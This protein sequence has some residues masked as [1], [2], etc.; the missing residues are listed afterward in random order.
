MWRFFGSNQA[1]SPRSRKKASRRQFGFEHLEGRNLLAVTFHGGQLL[2]HVETQAVYL[3]SD[4]SNSTLQSQSAAL[5]QYLGYLVQ[6]P[7]M[8]MLTQ[9]GYGV[10]Q[11]TSTAGKE[12]NLNISKTTGITDSQIRADLQSAITSGQLRT[13]DAS[14]LYVVYVEPGVAIKL[15]TDSS[16]TSFLGYHGAFAGRTAAGA[17][18]DIRYAVMAYPGTPNPSSTS[19]GFSTSF[20]QLTSVTSHELAEAVT[21]PD[22]NYKALGW[23]DDQLNGEIGDLTSRTT[24]LN[25]YTVQDVVNKNDQVIAPATGGTT[26]PPTTPPPTP[27]PSLAAPQNVAITALSPTDAQLSWSG[28][29]GATGYRIYQVSGTQ[30]T[31][32]A[33]VAAAT[34][35]VKITGLTPGSTASFRVQAFQ[36]TAVADSA[37]VSVTMPAKPTLAAPQVTATVISSSSVQL[38]WGAVAGAQGFNIYWWNGFRA[39]LIGTVGGS[40]RSV[41]VTGLPGGVNQFVVEAFSGSVVADSAWVA[42]ALPAPTRTRGWFWY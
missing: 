38:S 26:T 22:V 14:R 37:V 6:S 16:T 20:Q 27:V 34:T 23:Y 36:G 11:G 8:D 19:Q 13:P 3:G 10:G 5:D 35:S 30:A 32:L 15:G 9:A 2:P 40:S 24:V 33:T 29:N 18:A 12:L 39:V 17:P 28:V 7:Y 4:R 1:S 21:D 31:L 41:Q 42:V 25:G